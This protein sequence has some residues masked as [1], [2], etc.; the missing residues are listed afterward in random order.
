MY[1]LQYILKTKLPLSEEKGPSPQNLSK[2]V[3]N[4]IILNLNIASYFL[5]ILASPDE[6]TWST[7]GGAINKTIKHL[8]LTRHHQK[9]VEITWHMVNECKE[10]EQEYT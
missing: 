8:D 5:N 6:L 4:K 10:M 7:T 1:Q 9:T 2:L 3:N